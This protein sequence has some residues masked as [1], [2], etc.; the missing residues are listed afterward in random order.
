M[1]VLDASV[2]I[3]HLHPSDAHHGAATSILLTAAPDV[4]MVHPITLAGVLVGGV[5]IAMGAEMQADLQATGIRLVSRDDD[6]PRRACR[7]PPR[8]GVRAK[9]GV[10]RVSG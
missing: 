10:D 2:L 1:I 5:R 8:P 3:A 6:E 4:L 9:S 7:Y